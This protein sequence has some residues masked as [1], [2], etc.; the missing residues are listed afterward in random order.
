MKQRHFRT[1]PPILLAAA[2]LI[3]TASTAPAGTLAG[4]VMGPSSHG[5]PGAVVTVSTGS[6]D[7]AARCDR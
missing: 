3:A 2:L 6:T 7:A 1:A 4:V 5:L